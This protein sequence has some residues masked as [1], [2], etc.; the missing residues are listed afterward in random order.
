MTTDS[1]T[2][3]QKPHVQHKLEVQDVRRELADAE[4]HS[5]K[6]KI[7]R[8]ESTLEQVK[9]LL[10]H[11][12]FLHNGKLSTG[13]IDYAA[14]RVETLS[15]IFEIAR[16]TMNKCCQ[17]PEQ[18]YNRFLAD[19]GD[20]VGLTFGRDLVNR[21]VQRDLLLP[22]QEMRKLLELW[23]SFENDTGAGETKIKLYS[24]ERITIQL[25]NNPLRRA[26]TQG[27]AH[28]GFYKAY[29][30]SL[31]NEIFTVRARF[32]RAQVEGANVQAQNVITVTEQP[33][34]EDNCIF[35]VQCRTEILTRAFDLLTEAY[36]QFYRVGQHDDYSPCMSKARAA[37]VTAQMEAIEL[38]EERAPRQLYLVYKGLLDAVLF[39]LMDDTYQR[40][41]KPLHFESKTSAKMER[42][43]AWGL[44]RDTRRC[45][46]AIEE[47]T[48]DGE[49]KAALR[50]QAVKYDRIA[51]LE[52]LA[53]KTSDLSSTD[54]H[55]LKELL[56]HIKKGVVLTEDRQKSLI[57][58]IQNIGGK[59]WEV[60]RPILS[61]VLTAAL[62]KQFGLDT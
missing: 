3:E 11:V 25:R 7:E 8:A 17:N 15:L 31:I 42:S 4:F 23:A 5:A 26:E 1:H 45:V 9:D 62:K 47:L 49:K 54:K 18:A 24:P 16:R 21:L 55:N 35:V 48:L 36:D 27:H 41:S 46:Y 20:E 29:L 40:V 34:A 19:L 43:T 28:C 37:L 61:D 60:A 33:D 38:K 52:E 12:M 56:A 14:F 50:N 13:T 57:A 39:K 32:I 2:P 44:L 10:A 58:V 53:D 6:E 59:A 22:L 51:I 30:G